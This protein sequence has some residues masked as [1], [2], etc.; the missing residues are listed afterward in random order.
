MGKNIWQGAKYKRKRSN[1]F[2]DSNTGVVFSRTGKVIGEEPKHKNFYGS[3][4]KKI[5]GKK[6]P[7]SFKPK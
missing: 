3:D 5:K 7:E 1:T 4:P 2:R 6:K